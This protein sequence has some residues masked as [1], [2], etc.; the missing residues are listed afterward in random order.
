MYDDGFLVARDTRRRAL[1][2]HLAGTLE[3]TLRVLFVRVPQHGHLEMPTDSGYT[4]LTVDS[5]VPVTTISQWD[6]YA[7]LYFTPDSGYTGPD[8]VIW[9]GKNSALVPQAF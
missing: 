9:Y 5:S 2:F 3:D 8:T 6:K 4:L 7:Y 1:S